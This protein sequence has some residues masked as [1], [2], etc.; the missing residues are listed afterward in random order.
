[1]SLFKADMPVNKGIIVLD[2]KT[3]L[4]SDYKP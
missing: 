1:M 3:G 2:L 4:K